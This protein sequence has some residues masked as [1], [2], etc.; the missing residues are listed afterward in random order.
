MSND[1]EYFNAYFANE[2][3][4]IVSSYWKDADDNIV[5]IAMSTEA[6]DPEW[7]NLLE[8]VT[9]DEIHE[10]TWKYIKES[11][12][13]YKDQVIEIA[14]ERGWLVNMDDGGTSDFHKILVDMLFEPFDE[15]L[16]KEK[17]FFFKIH[18]FEKDVI[19]QCKDKEAKKKIRRA[20][21]FIE[22][23]KAAIEIL[24]ANQEEA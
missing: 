19:N 1:L 3:R 12:Q 11:E 5:S 21:T 4:T 15:N 18:L 23:I 6:D 16:H 8:Q 2:D 13:A 14:K 24:D 7:I 22:A 17:L 9:V 20:G 10:N